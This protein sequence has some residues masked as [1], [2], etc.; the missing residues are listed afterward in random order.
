ML[1]VY[2]EVIVQDDTGTFEYNHA[3]FSAL[4]MS[5]VDHS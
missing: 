5:K 2:T 1:C 3:S 4:N